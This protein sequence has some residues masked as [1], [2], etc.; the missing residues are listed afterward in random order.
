MILGTNTAAC[1]VRSYYSLHET[2]LKPW[3][4]FI[5][6]Y[7]LLLNVHSVIINKT[8]LVA[9]IIGASGECL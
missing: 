8:G 3:I 6:S 5:L 7:D 1:M 4:H 2:D 9:E